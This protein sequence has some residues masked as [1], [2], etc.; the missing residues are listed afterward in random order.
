MRRHSEER[1]KFSSI[2]VWRRI[3]IDKKIFCYF[4]N[5]WPHPYEKSFQCWICHFFEG[6]LWSMT[7][8]ESTFWET[9]T[10]LLCNWV[11]FDFIIKRNQMG[12]F[13]HQTLPDG[14]ISSIKLNHVDLLVLWQNI[15]IKE[16][17]RGYGSPRFEKQSHL[18]DEICFIVTHCSLIIRSIRSIIRSIIR[19]LKWNEK[20]IIRITR[21]VRN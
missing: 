18:R 20:R 13:Y 1:G 11:I 19:S 14:S 21:F 7:S 15:T 8:E 17:T 6:F 16:W 12:R 5:G 2:N 4:L 9:L 3:I 10:L